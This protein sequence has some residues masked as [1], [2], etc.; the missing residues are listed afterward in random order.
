MFQPSS[1]TSYYFT[2]PESA[3]SMATTYYGKGGTLKKLIKSFTAAFETL[4]SDDVKALTALECFRIAIE[5]K[6]DG[7]NAPKARELYKTE[8]KKLASEKN[9]LE[10]SFRG[11]SEITKEFQQLGIAVNCFSEENNFKRLHDAVNKNFLDMTKWVIFQ[12]DPVDETTDR[13]WTALHYACF[14]VYKEQTALLLEYG[15]NPNRKTIEGNT[16]VH[17]ACLNNHLPMAIL[18]IRHGGDPTIL[19]KKGQKA[20]ELFEKVAIGNELQG[21]HFPLRPDLPKELQLTLLAHLY[22]R[23]KIYQLFEATSVCKQW[24]NS[25]CLLLGREFL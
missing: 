1:L 24:Q 16:A 17:L 13:L 7:K 5:L 8:V 18:L 2:N 6:T 19:N 10:C 22:S 4:R 20:R 9:L 21:I 23:L 3:S 25:I 12:G 11:F 14:K 15:A